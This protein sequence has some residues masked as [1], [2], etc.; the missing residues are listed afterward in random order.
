MKYIISEHKLDKLIFE[1]IDDYLKFKNRH[2]F[3]SFI[4]YSEVNNNDDDPTIEYDYEDGRL[5]INKNFVMLIADMFGLTPKQAQLKI[6][7]W[8]ALTED[9]FPE[10]MES[11]YLEGLWKQKAPRRD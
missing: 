10:Y 11:P 8:F 3:D 5:F 4:I 2:S 6:Y 1:V 9:V 7:D